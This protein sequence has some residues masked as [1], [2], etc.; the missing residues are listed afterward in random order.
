L[1]DGQRRFT[2]RR[3]SHATP[4]RSLAPLSNLLHV[5]EATPRGETRWLGPVLALTGAATAAG[6]T[7]DGMLAS[8]MV[9]YVARTIA[10]V[11]AWWDH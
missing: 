1:C 7:R 11:C 10:E 2:R 6:A 4:S 9:A 8:G 5:Q 3:D